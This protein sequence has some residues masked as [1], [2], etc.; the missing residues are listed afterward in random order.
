MLL[1]DEYETF[2]CKEKKLSYNTMRSY[3]RDL[4]KYTSYLEYMEIEFTKVRRK[5]IIDYLSSMQKNGQAPSSVSRMMASLRSYYGF[6]LD[7]G[8]I[9]TD[10]TADVKIPKLP[11][12]EFEILTPYETEIF[13]NQP[14]C[15]NFKGYR[16]KAMLELIYATGIKVSELIALKINDLNI[17]ESYV[18]CGTKKRLIPFGIAAKNALRQYLENARFEK[19]TDQNNEYIFIN[20]KGEKLSRQGFWKIIKY[21]K[22]KAKINKEINPNILRHSFAVH[23]MENGADMASVCEM[24]GHSAISSTKI[25]AEITNKHLHDVYKKAHPRV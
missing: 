10:P 20:Q 21:Y 9:E 3:M 7:N 19:T 17:E 18:L 25:Y 13:L 24:L 22:D 12:R 23:L 4:H 8:V 15:V 6:M 11:K 16:D 1:L 14:E 2:L 5:N